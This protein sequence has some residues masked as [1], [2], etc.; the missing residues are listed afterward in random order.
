MREDEGTALLAWRRRLAGLVERER[1]IPWTLADHLLLGEREHGVTLR[2]AARLSGLRYGTVRNM[3]STA[4][5]Y[6][7]HVRHD[8]L[9]FAHHQELLGCD[10]DEAQDLL[11]LAAAKGWSPRG[12]RKE[13]ARRALLATRRA[14]V[15]AAPEADIDVRHCSAERLLADLARSAVDAIITD[16]P[17]ARAW[18]PQYV[19]LARLAGDVLAPEGVLAV[20][21]GGFGIDEVATVQAMHEHL[22]L[23]AVLYV[24]CATSNCLTRIGRRTSSRRRSPSRCSGAG[25][26]SSPP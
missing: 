5:A 6:P 8:N 11:G 23:F 12:L 4:R 18:L 1:R 10:P 26:R 24:V 25:R 7:C 15:A 22:A 20:M 14:L 13:R 2:D 16:L 17:Y 19:D 3:M 21:F 9:T